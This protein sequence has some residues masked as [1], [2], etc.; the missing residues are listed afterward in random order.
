MEAA[1]RPFTT[2]PEQRATV[3]A[4]LRRQLCVV[5]PPVEDVDLGGKTAIVTG[6]N[7]GIGLESARQLLGLGLSRLILAVRNEQKGQ[8]ARTTLLSEFKLPDDAIDVWKL[9][10]LSYDSITTFAARAKTLDRLDIAVLNAGIFNQKF[11]MVNPHPASSHEETIQLNVL[12][13]TLLSILLL[14]VLKTKSPSPSNTPGRLVIVSSDVSS[15]AKFKERNH[16]PLLPSFS[17]PKLFDGW[18]RYCTSKL[19]SQLAISELA[20]RVDPSI[21]IITLPNPGLCYGTHLGQLP[22]ANVVDMIGSFLKR[23]FGR[24]P[25]VGTRTITAGA[26][27]FGREAHGQYVED[28]K[29]EPLAPFAY[30][31]EGE[32]VAQLLWDEIM[33]E[34]SFAKVEEILAGLETPSSE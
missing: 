15:F 30:E 23:I 25:S 24:R 3:R 22:E 32:R 29:L 28:G 19:L 27:K 33:Q 14:P 18:E 31:A 20:K 12:S 13:T 17:D 5:P 21:A 4:T 6:S 16:Q 34:L 9:D 2:P 26:V 11:N 8:Q 10:M 7:G 1:P